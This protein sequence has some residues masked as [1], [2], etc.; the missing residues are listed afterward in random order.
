MSWGAPRNIRLHAQSDRVPPCESYINN[1]FLIY[2]NDEL[3][4]RPRNAHARTAR[5]HAL[6]RRFAS[7]GYDERLASGSQRIQ[8][9]S[10]REAAD[11]GTEAHGD[12]SGIGSRDPPDPAGSDRRGGRLW[13]RGIHRGADSRTGDPMSKIEIRVWVDGVEL[14]LSPRMAE[15]FERFTDPTLKAKWGDRIRNAIEDLEGH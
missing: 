13:D 6:S 15:M 4:T 5:P 10:S 2:E 8:S 9:R 14:D 11:T 7:L 1:Q 12:R 3:L